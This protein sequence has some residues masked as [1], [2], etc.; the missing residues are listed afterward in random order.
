MIKVGDLVKIKTAS[1]PNHIGKIGLVTNR[2]V[3]SSDSWHVFL[4]NDGIDVRFHYS[5]LEKL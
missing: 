5:R 1:G 3:Y 2:T 4:L